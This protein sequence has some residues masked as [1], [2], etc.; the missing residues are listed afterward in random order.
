M[1][2]KVLSGAIASLLL[3][4]CQSVGDIPGPGGEPINASEACGP[5][6]VYKCA[7]D[8]PVRIPLTRVATLSLDADGKPNALDY[9]GTVTRQ[10]DTSGR[11]G[12]NCGNAPTSPF[13]QADIISSDQVYSSRVRQRIVAGGRRGV[14]L[15]ADITAAMLE[16]GVAQDVIE[17][18]DANIESGVQQIEAATSEAVGDFQVYKVNPALLRNLESSGPEERFASCV[19]ELRGGDWMLY[20]A[21]SGWHVERATNTNFDVT[22]VVAELVAGISGTDA[23]LAGLRA[24]LSNV[25][26]ESVQS[27]TEP[28]FIVIGVSRWRSDRF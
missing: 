27:A 1:T 8:E 7:P 2:L 20:H 14:G 4:G 11:S 26:A 19:D 10:N 15:K 16:A 13:T 24:Q 5:L 28:Y 23:D 17:R 9:L 3:I 25:A 12:S 18:I 22:A 21:I 6:A